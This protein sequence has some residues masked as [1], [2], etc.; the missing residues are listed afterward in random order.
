MNKAIVNIIT[1]SLPNVITCNNFCDMFV[2]TIAPPEEKVSPVFG[3]SGSAFSVPTPKTER[4]MKENV[5]ENLLDTLRCD[6][7]T[8]AF[9][10]E[11]RGYHSINRTPIKES[12]WEDF[13]Y[14]IVSKVCTVTNAA[15]GNHLSGSDMCFNEQGISM[16]SAKIEKDNSINIS[17]YRLT[18]VCSDR[19]PGNIEEI[20]NEIN[21]RD[22][23]YNYYSILFRKENNTIIKYYWCLIDKTC[24][25]FKMNIDNIKAKIGKRGRNKD[26]Q[27]GWS[28]NNFDINFSM[29]SQLWYKLKYEDIYDYIIAEIEIDMADSKISYSDVFEL[30][31]N[32][33]K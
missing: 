31:N 20:V 32:N 33:K 13:N 30:I 1:P 27:V 2:P 11:I 3:S 10:S 12:V 19:T 29:S 16:K 21:K 7:I 9:N 22:Q 6:A 17:S 26:Q 14:N 24:S 18:K 5:R 25:I 28:S 8:S 23:S 4:F 15:N